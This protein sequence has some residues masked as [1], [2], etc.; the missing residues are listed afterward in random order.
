MWHIMAHFSK[1]QLF[2]LA[3]CCLN[4]CLLSP[5]PCYNC[6]VFTLF[7]GLSKFPTHLCHKLTYLTYFRPISIPLCCYI[8]EWKCGGS[9]FMYYVLDN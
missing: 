2:C 5:I 7:A 1:L 3:H 6:K 8:V 4:L 9:V